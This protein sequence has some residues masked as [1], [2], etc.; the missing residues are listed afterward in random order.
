MYPEKTHRLVMYPE[1]THSLVMYSCSCCIRLLLL[2]W[3]FLLLFLGYSGVKTVIKVTFLVI[4]VLT[5]LGPSCLGRG[6]RI[7]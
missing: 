7:Y 2:F 3:S 6:L 4:P 1:K 5:L